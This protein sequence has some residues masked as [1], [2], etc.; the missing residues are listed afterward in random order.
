[1]FLFFL[2]KKKRNRFWVFSFEKISRSGKNA[3]SAPR[4]FSENAMIGFLLLYLIILSVNAQ[5][6]QD[7]F[8]R[9]IN[10]L[11]CFSISLSSSVNRAAVARS[12]N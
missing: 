7:F 8:N 2:K 1:M 3:R 10:H 11:F 12:Y 4:G 5:S 9:T 6:A